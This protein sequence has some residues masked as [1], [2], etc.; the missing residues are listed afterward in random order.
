MVFFLLVQLADH[1]HGTSPLILPVQN[2]PKKNL[3]AAQKN[4]NVTLKCFSDEPILWLLSEKQQTNSHQITQSKSQNIYETHLDLFSV[5]HKFVGF[6]YC[7]K[8]SSLD[9]NLQTKFVNQ[10]ASKIYVFVDGMNLLG[11]IFF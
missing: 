3:L 4:E 8:N 10:L 9:S 2:E 6:Y 1:V 11:F 7:V 5:N